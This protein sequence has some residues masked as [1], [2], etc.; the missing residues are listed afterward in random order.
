MRQWA[1]LGALVMGLT[2]AAAAPAR[3]QVVAV[4]LAP[5]DNRAA[6]KA[7]DFPRLFTN[8]G[9]WAN[10]ARQTATLS[11]TADYVM[12][13]PDPQVKAALAFLANSN[14]RLDVSVAALAAGQT[15]CG[16]QGAALLPAA[17]T[18]ALVQ[19]LQGLGAE[20]GSFSFVMPLT[21]GHFAQGAAACRLSVDDAA[22]HLVA[23]AKVLRAAYPVAAFVDEETP[24]GIAVNRWMHDLNTWLVD[25]AQAT[26]KTCM[27]SRWISAGLRP[28]RT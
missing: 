8:P 26:G 22:Q 10:A 1:R 15:A 13:A 16:A 3:A 14:I 6:A 23:A 7:D 2:V 4:W 17:Q 27:E 28:G 9:G 18:Q 5:A 24:L 21:I 25:F 20:V 12:H 19:R 11:L